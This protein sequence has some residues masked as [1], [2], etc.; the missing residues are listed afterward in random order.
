MKKI[1]QNDLYIFA[2]ILH[3]CYRT[4]YFSKFDAFHKD[5][6]F[7]WKQKLEQL[8][9]FWQNW[10]EQHSLTPLTAQ[11]K[12]VRRQTELIQ[13]LKTGQYRTIYEMNEQILGG[14]AT[15]TDNV[16]EFEDYIKNPSQKLALNETALSWWRTDTQQA[17]WP[18]LS[19]LAI[20]ILSIPPMS[21]EV[22]RVF[23]GSRR[24][25]PWT[26]ASLKPEM[27]EKIECLKHYYRIEKEDIQ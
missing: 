19:K 24:T 6:I 17:R 11:E 12:I 16:D 1:W 13:S 10:Q 18:I 22:E 20:S 23:S 2:I 14:W 15:D 4:S 27:I 25:I 9:E 21:A 3:P 5:P 7:Q 26:R 8:K